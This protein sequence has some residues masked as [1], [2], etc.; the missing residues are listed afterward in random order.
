MEKAATPDNHWGQVPMAG[1]LAN[2]ADIRA[3]TPITHTLRTIL[4]MN[5]FRMVTSVVSLVNSP[6]G[7]LTSACQIAHSPRHSLKI[8]DPHHWSKR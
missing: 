1:K 5:A 4:G 3:L 8:L 7:L 6:V 2:N